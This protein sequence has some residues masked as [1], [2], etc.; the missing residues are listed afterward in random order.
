MNPVIKLVGSHIFNLIIVYAC[1][2]KII[3]FCHICTSGSLNSANLGVKIIRTIMG[4][5]LKFIKILMI[6]FEKSHYIG[7]IGQFSAVL[8]IH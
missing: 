4:L 1:F 3:L 7:E 5:M 2:F 8:K 6:S